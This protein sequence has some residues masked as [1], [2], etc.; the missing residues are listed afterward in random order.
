MIP[1]KRWV[2][3]SILLLIPLLA[4]SLMISAGKNLLTHRQTKKEEE[5]VKVAFTGDLLWEENFY[6]SHKHYQ[7]GHY[8]DAILPHLDSDL[9]I[10]NQ[11]VPI[12]GKE[13][14]I[15]GTAFTYNAPYEIAKQ[16]PKIGIDYV[17]LANN[18]I[19]DKGQ[20]GID[21]TLD[22]LDQEE[23][24]HTGVYREDEETDPISVVDVKGVKIA[25]LAYTYDTNVGRSG[26][27]SYFL[28]PAQT[29][30]KE[31]QDK[32]KKDVAKAQKK[33]DLVFVSMHWGTEFTYERTKTQTEVAEFL[34]EQGVDV[35]IG[36]HPHNIQP[37]TTLTNKDGKKT[38]VF[39]SLGNTTSASAAVKR[40]T[41]DFQNMYEIGALVNMDITKE[42]DEVALKNIRIIPIVNHF[43]YDH[44]NFR[45]IPFKEYTEKQAK[46]HFRA[47]FDDNFNIEW[48][49]H[50]IHTVF[51]D[52]G[53]LD[54]ED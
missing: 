18:H 31:Y 36:N 26:N 46:K 27:V 13:L 43:E 20:E 51:D 38:I 7:F 3:I 52:S 35:I 37:A 21:H 28:S 19:L 11:E 12:G 1:K 50:E 48:L 30:D 54:L 45:L 23:I 47:R 14:G 29:F 40:A 5:T 44:K 25:I 10:A 22:I 49:S 8:F 39:Y 4:I 53:F 33:A 15:S 41:P 24:G 34:N 42:Q 17:T 32:L 2:R 16:F 6:E 9:T